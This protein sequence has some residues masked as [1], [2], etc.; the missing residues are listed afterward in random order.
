M[1][2]VELA[3]SDNFH[4]MQRE[5]INYAMLPDY[6]TRT[7]PILIRIVDKDLFQ[8]TM[9]KLAAYV[10]P[11]L[12]EDTYA[13]F[14]DVE[15]GGLDAEDEEIITIQYKEGAINTD[16]VG[17]QLVYVPGYLA[18]LALAGAST[19]MVTSVQKE[20]PKVIIDESKMKYPTTA[21]TRY[22][23]YRKTSKPAHAAIF[24]AMD[25][26]LDITGKT[27]NLAVLSEKWRDVADKFRDEFPLW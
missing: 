27:P 6:L 19:G 22:N 15:Y 1:G 18:N 23:R 5:K 7:N 10:T 3:C 9:E 21:S 16:K 2:L 24:L 20:K 26:V 12:T 4:R 25:T 11:C 17:T 14:A 8:L 13:Q